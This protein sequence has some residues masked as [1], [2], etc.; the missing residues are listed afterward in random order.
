MQKITRILIFLLS[1]QANLLIAGPFLSKPEPAPVWVDIKGIDK[2]V[3]LAAF[4]NQ[5]S[6]HTKQIIK[7]D[8]DFVLQSTAETRW[9][10]TYFY[11]KRLDV[12]I[13]GDVMNVA[14]WNIRRDVDQEAQA[15]IAAARLGRFSL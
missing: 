12:D 5:A 8:G 1:M 11:G 6:L 3:L 10:I 4:Y 7:V 13:S 9:P 15:I 14:K 2:A